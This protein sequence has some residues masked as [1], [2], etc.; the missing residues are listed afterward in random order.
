[1]SE[2]SS[3]PVLTRTRVIAL[4]GVAAGMVIG[5]VVEMFVQGAMESTGWFGPTL[6]TVMS[7][8]MTNFEEIQEKLNALGAATDE[9]ERE[10]LRQ[11]LEDLLREQERLTSQ[12]H[13]ELGSS[14][15]EIERLRAQS[16]ETSGIAAGADVWLSPGQSITV[17][18]R[19]N[20][21][22]LVSVD[23]YRRARVNLSGKV[24]VMTAGDFV[25]APVGD[26]VWKVF[27]KQ[28]ARGDDNSAV[29]FDVV[30]PGE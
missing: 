6:E 19:D 10:T 23:G 13:D 7:E 29:G 5:A 2:K 1:M 3:K 27:Y 14:Q 21:L 12:T 8:Q 17:G 9:S 30:D 26:D 15:R 4:S 18:S 11:E 28:T 16:L 22:S 20:V 24:T 25:E